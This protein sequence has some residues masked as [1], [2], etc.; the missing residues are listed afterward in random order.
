MKL[1]LGREIR[2]EK[3]RD[4][5]YL[6]WYRMSQSYFATMT[7]HCTAAVFLTC[8]SAFNE[9]LKSLTPGCR[10]IFLEGQ[11]LTITPGRRSTFRLEDQSLTPKKV[12]ILHMGWKL[13]QSYTYVETC[14][15][16]THSFVFF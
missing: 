14:S 12:K 2:L 5:T 8:R 13:H 11:S 16:F 3:E 7:L 9:D 6:L 10:S 1:Y 15:L 4:T